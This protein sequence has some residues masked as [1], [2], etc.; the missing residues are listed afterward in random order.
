VRWRCPGE[1]HEAEAGRFGAPSSSVCEH[2]TRHP[3]DGSNPAVSVSVGRLWWRDSARR[4][5]SRRQRGRAV[6]RD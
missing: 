5:A 4:I 2:R 3:P 6:H 1:S